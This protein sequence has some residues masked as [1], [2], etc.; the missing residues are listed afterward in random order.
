MAALTMPHSQRRSAWA[1][2]ATAAG[3]GGFAI[4]TVLTY[5]ADE[6]LATHAFVGRRRSREKVKQSGDRTMHTRILR[7]W[8]TKTPFSKRRWSTSRKP[9]GASGQPRAS[10]ALRV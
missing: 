7:L 4:L 1:S 6:H 8:P 3:V 9:E 10:C 2:R 5:V